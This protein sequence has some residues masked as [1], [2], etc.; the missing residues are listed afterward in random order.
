VEVCQ[1][2]SRADARH[3][4]HRRVRRRHRRY[5]DGGH[6]RHGLRVVRDVGVRRTLRAST[7]IGIGYFLFAAVVVCTIVAL[8]SAFPHGVG[9]P[10]DGPAVI[11]AVAVGATVATL[12][13]DSTA[14]VPTAVAT[15]ILTTVAT[16]ACFLLLGVL[17]LANVVRYV[18]Y[19]VVGG[20]LAGAGWL[21]VDG[22]VSV[23]TGSGITL[24]ALPT[25][26]RGDTLVRVLPALVLVV[27]ALV[28]LRRVTTPLALPGLLVAVIIVF[29]VVLPVAGIPIATARANGWLFDAI[30]GGSLWQAPTLAL[31]QDARWDLIAANAATSATLVLIALLAFL[32]N[33]TGMELAAQ[34]DVDLN[35]EL[36]VVGVA[37]ALSGLGAGPVAFHSLSTSVLSRRPSPQGRLSSLVMAGVFGVVLLGGG[38]VVDLVPTVVAA[39]VLLFLGVD[40]LITWLFEIR[41]QLSGVE[42]ALVVMIAVT[43]AVVGVLQ[44]VALGVGLALVLFVIEYARGTPI[45][46]T[47]SGHTH[48]SRVDRPRTH[49]QVLAEHGDDI[50]IIQLQRFIFFGTANRLLDAVRAQLDMAEG[51]AARYIVLDFARATGLD[52]SAIA[53][54]AKMHHLAAPRGVALVLT[55]LPPW[56]RSQLQAMPSPG[57][58]RT[59]RFFPDLDHG[60]EWCEA[61]VLAAELSD[62]LLE[63]AAATKELSGLGHHMTPRTLPPGGRL[64]TQGQRP[65][66]LY[67]LQRG[68]PTAQIEHDDGRVVRLRTMHP[69]VFV[70]ELSLCADAP[71]S[72]SVVAD[73]PSTVL[74][75]STEE[76]ERLD[77]EQPHVAAAFHRHIATLA[78]ERLLDATASI[79]ALR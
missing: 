22:G 77:A 18:P 11:L 14:L 7:G 13:A 26:L 40:F 43:M 68:R 78:S 42:Y 5:R 4:C 41:T 51:S 71:A 73:E 37:N 20:F 33:A 1:Q 10:Q 61:Q 50:S 25:L 63:D 57:A 49:R 66:G 12:P 32:L 29:H 62:E 28:V 47:L 67:Y 79:A 53:S 38:P 54:F 64:I 19:P 74:F 2:G 39:G 58:D 15:I 45:R 44:G 48:H 21:L 59:W 8:A 24:G 34:R 36:R 17:R 31:L 6:G 60:V 72:A 23:V 9:A 16:G 27:V 52:A 55:D 46:R 70:G 3:R 69:G 30:P 76:L 35:R 75:L 56:V 65:V